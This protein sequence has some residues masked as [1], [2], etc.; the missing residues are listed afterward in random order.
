MWLLPNNL[1]TLP[2]VPDMMESDSDSTEFS[3]LAARSL[4]SRSKPLQPP[5]WLKKWKRESWLQHLSGQTLKPSQHGSFT[6]AWTSYLRDS[7]ASPSPQQGKAG[8]TKTPDTSGLGSPKQSDLFDQGWLSLKTS[9]E[10]SVPSSRGQDGTTTRE[11]RYCFMSSESWKEEVTRLRG[12]SLARRKSAHLIGGSESSS[13]PT[14]AVMDTTGGSYKTEWKDGRAVSYHNHTQENPVAY[15]AKL[16]DAVKCGPPDQDNHNTPGS[17]Q[18]Q[19]ENWP[20]PATRDHHPQGVNHNT[21][22]KSSSL[23]TV[24]AKQYA[25]QAAQD[26]PNT[27]GNPQGQSENWPTPKAGCIEESYDTFSKRDSGFRKSGK[28][29]GKPMRSGMSLY[30]AVDKISTQGQCK[31]NPDWVESLMGLPIGWTDYASG[32]RTDR[33]RL[34]GNGVVPQT[35]SLAI[36][37]LLSSQPSQPTQPTLL[38]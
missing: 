25:V 2:F 20:T 22:A 11:L 24:I 14:P 26:N 10:S 36:S 17:R 4:L 16:A 12:E 31:L 35:A 3:E 18:G 30:T 28:S 9:L 34:L 7:R 5:A 23:S 21:K 33:L 6:D 37:S 38:P 1:P 8:Q 32:N 19:P 13:W 27:P 15:G 29:K